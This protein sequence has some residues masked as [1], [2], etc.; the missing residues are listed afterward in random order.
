M[1]LDYIGQCTKGPSVGA[2]YWLLRNQ[3]SITVCMHIHC[4]NRGS[5]RSVRPISAASS[6]SMPVLTG[7]LAGC[8]CSWQAHAWRQSHVRLIDGGLE[9]VPLPAAGVHGAGELDDGG[10]GEEDIV[11]AGQAGGKGRQAGGSRWAGE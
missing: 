11:A 8:S 1:R 9:P 6:D 3:A 5:R 4:C 7:G 10:G 2:Q